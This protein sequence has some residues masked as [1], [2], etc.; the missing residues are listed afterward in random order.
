MNRRTFIRGALVSTAVVATGVPLYS[1]GFERHYLDKTTL[2][3][4]LG[5]N[6]PWRIAVL[7]D[8]H[9]DPLFEE[10][11]IEH[12]VNEITELKPDIILYTGDFVSHEVN[13]I[14]DLAKLLSKAVSRLGSFAV[15]GNHDHWYGPQAVRD[16]LEN[17]GIRVLCND[18]WSLPDEDCL[19]LTG[20]DSYWAGKP[21]FTVFSRTP[22]NS[23]HIVLFHEPD[24]FTLL[25]DLRIKLQI[26][27]HTHGGQVRVPF[28]GALRLPMW[29]R[30]YDAGLFTLNG[31]S[32]Y[33]NRG[34]GTLAPHVRFDCR[35]ELTL[36]K[37]T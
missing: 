20:I 9:F 36:F 2:S 19:F 10:A 22:K 15:L 8:I 31:R 13:R 1:Y 33:V 28:F 12:V 30:H 32:L 7:G 25:T 18:S 4:A 21:D 37:L 3:H 27:G 24:P 11:Y 23:R 6:Q 29:G 5:L 17:N 14:G 34:I 16:A 35:P 26:S